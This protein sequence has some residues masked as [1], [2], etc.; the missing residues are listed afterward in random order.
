MNFVSLGDL[1]F[2]VK[3]YNCKNSVI[4]TL[5]SARQIEICGTSLPVL[6]KGLDKTF[7]CL[8]LISHVMTINNLWKK[9]SHCYVQYMVKSIGELCNK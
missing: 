4:A 9:K 1:C 6:S 8:S 3:F 7:Q 5:I 2:H